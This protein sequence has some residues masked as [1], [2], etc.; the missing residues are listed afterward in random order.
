M[1]LLFII[2]SFI[3]FVLSASPQSLVDYY[4]NI[5]S[6]EMLIVGN[7]FDKA[8]LFY[9]KANKIKPLFSVDLKNAVTAAAKTGKVKEVLFF[10]KKLVQ[11]GYKIEGF[12]TL[13][14]ELK[15]YYQKIVRHC[16]NVRLLKSIN[17][18]YRDSLT[19]MVNI[20]QSLLKSP[21]TRK[22]YKDSIDIIFAS[23]ALRLVNMIN[24]YGFPSEEKIGINS[25]SDPAVI[26]IHQRGG[27]KNQQ[28][29]FSNI[30]KSAVLKGEY[31]NKTGALLIENAEGKQGRIYN[32]LS[33]M[34][35]SFDT[36]VMVQNNFGEL[37]KKD[38]TFFTNWGAEL[39]SDSTKNK[40]DER[41][42]ELYLDIVDNAFKKAVYQL[43]HPEFNLGNR[44]SGLTIKW[45]NYLNFLYMYNNFSKMKF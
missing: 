35:G 40:F 29:N 42:K 19:I 36:V 15:S 22:I 14:S 3:P 4:K 34:R 37:M 11:I 6:A 32:C 5:D 27:E 17:L 1:K 33:L 20:D 39:I 21:E 31:Y 38:T 7:N 44:D 28:I 26:I 9:H 10:S 2:F 45:K 41:R 30:V 24:R 16:H 13:S 23:N 43:L 25:E 8:L 18:T 12:N